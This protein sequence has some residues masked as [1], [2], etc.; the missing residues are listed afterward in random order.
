MILF[1]WVVPHAVLSKQI[2]NLVGTEALSPQFY[3]DIWLKS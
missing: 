1:L 3:I 2:H